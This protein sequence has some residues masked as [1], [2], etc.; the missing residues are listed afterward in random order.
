MIGMKSMAVVSERGT[1]TI[2]NAVRKA[3]RIRPGDLIEFKPQGDSVILRHMVGKGAGKK[4]SL[5]DSEWREFDKLVN[6]Q[7]K[8]GAYKS[9]RD[10]K[11]AKSHSRRLMNGE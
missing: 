4:G 5:S 11:Q 8:E 1:V 7:L 6:K 2:P 10:I 3:A 9:Y